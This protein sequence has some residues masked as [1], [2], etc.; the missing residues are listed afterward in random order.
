VIAAALLAAVMAVP[1]PAAGGSAP[2]NPE[3]SVK[4]GV[5]VASWGGVPPNSVNIVPMIGLPGEFK[6]LA[7]SESV[8]AEALARRL[9]AAPRGRRALLIG[10]YARSFWGHR[11]D[12][13]EQ[14][15][16]KFS[17]PW[18]DSA[19]K[20]IERDWPRI[21]QLTKYC[22]GEVD[23]LVADF[24]DWCQFIT[25][26]IGD[27][28]IEA[29]RADP[30]WHQAKYGV[31]SLAEQLGSLRDVPAR[32]IRGTADGNYFKWNLAIGRVT[33][34]AMNEALW[35]T[36]RSAFPNLVGS[37]YQG[38]RSMDRPAP[39]LNGHQQPQDN[40]F[41]NAASPSL[42]GEVSS[43][44]NLFVDPQDPSRI[45]WQG[46]VHMKR[47]PWQS[48][49][50]CQQQ[51]RS[52][53]RGAPTLT[54]VPWVAH[55]S[56][57][58]DVA[59]AGFVGFPKDP[60]CYDEN[61]RHVALLGTP[62]FL[63]WRSMEAPPQPDTSRLDALISDINAH[64]LG[65]IKEPADV[66]PVSFLSEVVVTGGR[67]HDGTWMWRVSASPEVAMLREVGTGREWAP[68]AETLGFWVE[69]TEKAAP[70]WEVAR[71]RDPSEP[72]LA[73]P[74]KPAPPPGQ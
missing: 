71:R 6:P 54:L 30:R 58:G 23:L 31:P 59:G 65:R 74:I 32:S 47:G 22:G 73:R 37:N 10:R 36:A 45:A 61:V 40:V 50:M 34:A 21:L 24:E 8:D 52:C 9:K 70:K 16:L 2:A 69:T 72:S 15:A 63:W 38:Q 55:L 4:D 3:H 64:T 26:G 53:V 56:Y 41:G 14:G 29:L 57:E 51:A 28:H 7:E 46:T 42:Y 27:T 39:D 49:L 1:P 20:A 17:T 13:T 60:R 25:W 62:T 11:P 5:W 44:V 68:T 33:A 18:P 48:F 66:N 67:R 43:I 12:Q 35:K 19:I